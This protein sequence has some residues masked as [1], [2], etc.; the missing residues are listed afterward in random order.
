MSCVTFLYFGTTQQ[1]GFN[2]STK[3]QR[4]IKNQQRLFNE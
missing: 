4:K 1:Q 2:S 3:N